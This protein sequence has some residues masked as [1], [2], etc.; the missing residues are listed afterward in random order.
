MPSPMPRL[1]IDAIQ[2]SAEAKGVGRYAYHVCLQLAARLPEDWSLQIIIP[3]EEVGLFPLGF[4]GQL[5]P[6]RKTSEIVSAVFN[7][8]KQVKKLRPQILLK[9]HEGAG[10]VAG[11]PT[12]IICHDIDELIFEAQ[13]T[14]RPLSRQ[15]IDGAKQ[16]LRRRALQR[17]DFI[18][19]NSQFTRNG[20]H[21]Y[22]RVPNHKTA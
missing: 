5:I 4:R 17:S 6:V 9:T 11:V 15:L 8:R 16:Y 18:I 21:H 1:L 2:V 10:Y 19:C 22:Y 14:T 20:V 3:R 7:L 12:V 13:G